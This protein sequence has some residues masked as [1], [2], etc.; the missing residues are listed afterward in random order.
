[1]SF[2]SFSKVYFDLKIN[3]Y[4]SKQKKLIKELATNHSEFK[5]PTQKSLFSFITYF[6]CFFR[7][8]HFSHIISLS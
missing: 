3:T 7:K 6:K 1:M 5:K 2:K 8:N 4:V